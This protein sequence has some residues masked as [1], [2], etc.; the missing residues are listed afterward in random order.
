[1]ETPISVVSARQIVRDSAK[2]YFDP[3]SLPHVYTYTS[4]GLLET[5][6]CTDGVTT[7]VKTYTYTGSNLTEESLWERQ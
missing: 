7:W 1:M 4:G 2:Y 3:S 6:T 5:D